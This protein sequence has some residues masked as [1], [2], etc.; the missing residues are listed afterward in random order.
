MKIEIDGWKFNLRFSASHFIPFH[1]KCSRLHGH[2]YGIKLVLEGDLD[3]NYMLMDF[4]ELKKAIREII[5]K[6]DHHVLLPK[7]SKFIDIQELEAR[8]IVS[9]QDKEYVFP[10]EDVSF[11]DVEVTTAEEISEYILEKLLSSI[12]V[13]KNIRSIMLCVEE[14]PGQ[15]ACTERVF[16]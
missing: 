4:I 6:I 7:K 13:Q 5:E 11:I 10:S 8:V 2:D 14:G 15:G 3:E 16:L 1:G 9:F 12:N